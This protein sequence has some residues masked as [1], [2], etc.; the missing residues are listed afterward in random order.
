MQYKPTRLSLERYVSFPK[1][2]KRGV[3][4]SWPGPFLFPPQWLFS[5]QLGRRFGR[6]GSVENGG[7]CGT[8]ARRSS[9]SSPHSSPM[10]SA[11]DGWLV[12]RSPRRSDSCCSGVHV[13]PAVITVKQWGRAKADLDKAE[14]RLRENGF[15]CSQH[16]FKVA[17][18]RRRW[19]CLQEAPQGYCNPSNLSS[20]GPRLRR[21]VSFLFLESSDYACFGCYSAHSPLSS[22]ISNIVY[23]TS[24]LSGIISLR[25][26]LA[27]HQTY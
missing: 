26:I 12:H 8:M 9:S 3:A 18:A 11:G 19:R 15:R 5:R 10:T 24:T 20:R 25:I 6:F 22:L 2:T 17:T 1:N 7:I 27:L 14:M 4:H 23:Y 13:W 16:H 21:L